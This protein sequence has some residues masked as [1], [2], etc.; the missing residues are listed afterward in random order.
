MGVDSGH[1]VAAYDEEIQQLTR[2]FS[3]MGGLAEKQ[4]SDSLTA[5]ERRDSELAGIVKSSDKNIDNLENEIDALVVRMLAL[6]QPMANDLRYIISTLRTAADLERIGDYSKNIGKRT[7]ALNQLP[8]P[9]MTRGIVR[10]GRLVQSMLK[11]VLDAYSQGNVEKAIGVWEAD[12]EV[13]SLHTSLFR[14]LL[15][16]MMEDPRHI[17]PCTHLLFIAK[18]LE[19]IGD[20]ATN[21]AET[22]HFQ[23]QGEPLTER[24][25]KADAS[26]YAVVAPKT[27]TEE[28]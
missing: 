11:D 12:E 8:N 23:V 2:L 25:S 20:H 1:I 7:I 14:E 10:L 19:R 28:E 9:P 24:R 16:Y 6:R 4:L 27:D 5:V 18:N 21:I 15:T 13:D 26:N 17:T 3:R 22:I